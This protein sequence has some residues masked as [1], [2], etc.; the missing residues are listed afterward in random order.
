MDFGARAVTQKGRGAM[1]K[2]TL[3][4]D[5]DHIHNLG[6][7]TTTTEAKVLPARSFP[8]GNV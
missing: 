1:D 7:A 6:A 8:T 4:V 5:A 2:C 3:T